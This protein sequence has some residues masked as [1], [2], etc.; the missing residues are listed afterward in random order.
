MDVFHQPKETII[1]MLR[2]AGNTLLTEEDILEVYPCY[3]PDRM[4]FRIKDEHDGSERVV[5]GRP[6][7]SA[8]LKELEY[9]SNL[10]EYY[11]LGGF[12][13][14]QTMDK[15]YIFFDMPWFGYDMN[16]LQ[17][18]L[19]FLEY[20]G[21]GV[22]EHEFT[23]F[24]REQVKMYI[25]KLKVDFSKI[26]E[27]YGLIHGDLFQRNRPNNILWHPECDKFILIDSEAF[28][29]ISPETIERFNTQMVKVEEWMYDHLLKVERTS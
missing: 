10:V 24:T 11:D 5:K 2:K 16:K 15:S 27:K 7:D 1:D 21:E 23:G 9:Y 13:F 25:E 18:H 4:V 6:S 8:A 28:A 17:T 22:L 19:F 12:V 3:F 26:A 14:R 29:R 20:E